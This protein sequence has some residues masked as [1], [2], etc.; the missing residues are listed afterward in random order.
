MVVAGLQLKSAG[1]PLRDPV[2][3][4]DDKER[5]QDRDGPDRGSEAARED[6]EDDNRSARWWLG[7]PYW[8][9]PSDRIEY[10]PA[11]QVL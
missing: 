11:G 2:E 8:V 4:E 7:N 5:V 3:Q 6:R 9:G 1:R 10:R